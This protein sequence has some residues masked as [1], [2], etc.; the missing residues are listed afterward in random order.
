MS[1]FC[2]VHGAF[3]GAWCWDLLIPELEARGHEAVAMDLPLEDPDA[4]AVRYAEEVLQALQGAGDDVVLVGHSMSGLFIPI[5]ANQ[6]AVRKLVYLAAGIPKVGTSVV[7][8]VLHGNESDMFNPAHLN[9]DPSK[10]EAVAIEILFHDCKPEVA[11]WAISKLRHQASRVV[12][13]EISPIQAMPDIES[14][15]I[16][17]TEDRTVDPAWSKRT[18]RELLGVEAIA[19]PSGH[20]P[21]ISRPVHLAEVLTSLTK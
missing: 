13:A 15:Y 8:R 11:H 2:L 4:G 9:K 12:F 18:A 14:A 16:V 10:D 3:L 6:R 19:L 7:D 20:C 5:V 1:L 17:C 21:Q